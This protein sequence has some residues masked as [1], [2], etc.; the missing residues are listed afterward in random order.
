[1]V[2]SPSASKSTTPRRARPIRRW[3]STVRPSARPLETSRCLRSPVDAGSIPYSAVTQ[4]LPRP[5]IHL[6]TF[7][8]IDAVQ[9]TRVPP[10]SIRAEPSALPMKPGWIATG[11]SWS[12]EVRPSALTGAHPARDGALRRVRSLRDE[13]NVPN[14]AR[15]EAAGSGCRAAGTPRDPRSRGSGTRRPHQ[16]RRK[17]RSARE[18]ALDLLGDR[19]AGGD[20]L[21]AAPERPLEDR[22]HQRVVG[23]AKDHRVDA[24]LA[25][26]GRTRPRPAS[27]V[28]LVDLAA[29]LDQRRQLGRR[30]GVQVARPA[31]GLLRAPART[32]RWRPSPGSR[33]GQPGRCAWPP[34]RAATPV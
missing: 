16:G 7:S 23:A 27:T 8:S 33:S 6:G 32:R 30:D 21:H 24:R 31:R 3:I 13:L 22:A 4:P 2:R 12:A 1:M 15:S 19:L 11:R 34:P 10:H 18:L 28:A 14:V 5:C 25:S 29:G 9:M 26:A 20:D 17:A